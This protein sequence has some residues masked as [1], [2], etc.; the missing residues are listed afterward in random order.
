MVES[1]AWTGSTYAPTKPAPPPATE[2][3]RFAC[4]EPR[5]LRA[6]EAVAGAVPDAYAAAARV[7]F[8]GG[9]PPW[10]RCAYADLLLVVL[11]PPG[12]R[13]SPS[14]L[15]VYSVAGARSDTPTS[16]TRVV[17]SPSDWILAQVG[18]Y[19]VDCGPLS[20]DDCYRRAVEIASRALAA[21]PANRIVSISFTDACGSSRLS[22]ADGRESVTLVDCWR[23]T[24]GPS[25]TPDP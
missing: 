25:A 19:A 11:V 9:C 21:D 7:A 4:R 2:D 12:W 15:Q 8:P 20:G 24:P 14:D 10:A 23:P 1:V 3:P 22:R 5:C 18:G 13:G 17:G 6:A 16:V